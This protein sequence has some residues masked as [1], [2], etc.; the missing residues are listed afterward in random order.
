MRELSPARR[1]TPQ[2]FTSKKVTDV[3]RT[4]SIF[5][6]SALVCSLGLGFAVPAIGADGDENV[7]VPLART[8]NLPV[9]MEGSEGIDLSYETVA[10][11]S[12]VSE[13]GGDEQPEPE[14]PA[15]NFEKPTQLSRISS[16]AKQRPHGA[17]PRTGVEGSAYLAA[18]LGALALLGVGSVLVVR[19]A[20]NR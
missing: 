18:A 14:E 20:R 16:P 11:T 1:Q 5:A 9:N 6:A 15:Q 8:V 17:L 19:S 13:D 7:K 10:E 12:T 2:H 3:K 4:S